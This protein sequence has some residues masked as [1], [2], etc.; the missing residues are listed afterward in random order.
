MWVVER[1]WTDRNAT[2]LQGNQLAESVYLLW[3]VVIPLPSDEIPLLSDFSI[4]FTVHE[5]SVWVFIYEVR[6]RTTYFYLQY[7]HEKNLSEENVAKSSVN[8]FLILLVPDKTMIYRQALCKI[9]ILKWING[10]LTEE[11]LDE[12]GFRLE[13]SPQKSLRRLA[14]QVGKSKTSVQISDKKYIT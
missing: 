12:I 5:L 7:F 13:Q 11:K 8:N 10:F 6:Y 4:V 2:I 3:G 9:R 1:A 14:Q